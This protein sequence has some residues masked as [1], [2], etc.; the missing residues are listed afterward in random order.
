M[1]IAEALWGFRIRHLAGGMG[2]NRPHTC[3]DFAEDMNS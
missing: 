3:K 1:N 2:P